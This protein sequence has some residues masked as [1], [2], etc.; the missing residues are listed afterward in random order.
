[1]K[2]FL[3]QQEQVFNHNYSWYQTIRA[4]SFDKEYYH[5]GNTVG[6]EPSENLEARWY[7]WT[8]L[9]SLLCEAIGKSNLKTFPP[10][11][12]CPLPLFSFFFF[13][14]SGLCLDGLYIELRYLENSYLIMNVSV[15][16][17]VCFVQ[18]P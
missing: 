12:S 18:N 11:N 1:M 10:L 2:L 14:V 3:S 17:Y 5:H 15:K 16:C 13:T 4:T 8:M 7:L 6:I 9:R